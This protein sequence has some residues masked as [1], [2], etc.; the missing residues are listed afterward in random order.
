MVRDCSLSEISDGKYYGVNDMVKAGC[1]DCKGCSACC[2]GMG[3][4]IQLDP[5]DIYRL[6]V[7]L[8]KT[9]EQ[10]ATDHIELKVQRGIIL[11]NLKMSAEKEA[12]TFLNEEGRCSIHAHRPGICRIFPLGRYYEDR[13]FRYIMQVH[14]CPKPNKT[15][16][17]VSKWIDTK[18]IT[19][20]EQFIITWHY[21]IKDMQ[22]AIKTVTDEQQIRTISLYI[23]NQFYTK[24]YA[25]D[26]DFYSQ[27]AERMAHAK[28]IF[29]FLP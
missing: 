19:K 15:K 3:E 7:G 12:C 21:F 16:V 11:P 26:I 17:K 25:A 14:E 13:S 4:S 27:F 6:T 5:Y 28:S 22:E 10:L 24:P 8:G 9:F 23:L 29:T 20:N 2:H 1:D 18:D